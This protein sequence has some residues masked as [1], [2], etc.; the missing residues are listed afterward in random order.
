MESL[1]G[2]VKEEGFRGLFGGGWHVSGDM[3]YASSREGV[4]V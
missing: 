1:W 4:R 2:D 3:A